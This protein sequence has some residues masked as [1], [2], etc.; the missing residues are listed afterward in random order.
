MTPSMFVLVQMG[1]EGKEQGRA[2]TQLA[3]VTRLS[4]ILLD[5]R[6][7]FSSSNCSAFSVRPRANKRAVW[8]GGGPVA[9]LP[10]LTAALLR[11]CQCLSGPQD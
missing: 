2:A 6:R 3:A 7:G 1:L 11:F 9:F 8:G 10:H 4:V 5:Y